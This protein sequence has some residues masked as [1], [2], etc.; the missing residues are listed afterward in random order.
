MAAPIAYYTTLAGSGI[1]GLTALPQL[2][3][4]WTYG[5]AMYL[6]LKLT[7]D[8]I[9][10]KQM[11]VMSFMFAVCILFLC[12]TSVVAA[13]TDRLTVPFV[14]GTMAFYAIQARNSRSIQPAVV[15]A[16]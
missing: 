6:P 11:T 10:K 4:P 9:T 5:V 8:P 16:T 7:Q 14:I 1:F 13:L 12:T 2:F 15:T 3:K